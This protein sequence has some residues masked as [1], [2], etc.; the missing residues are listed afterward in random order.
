M[1]KPQEKRDSLFRK[2]NADPNRDNHNW[3]KQFRN[4]KTEWVGKTKREDNFRKH[5]KNPAATVFYKTFKTTK[6]QQHRFT[7]LIDLGTLNRF[8]VS[9]GRTRP[10]RL[11]V[12]H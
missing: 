7:N 6:E 11:K 12:S 2:W 9:V 5:G 10:A 3:Y 1:R 4:K 8:L